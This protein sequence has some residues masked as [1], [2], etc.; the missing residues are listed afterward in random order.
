VAIPAVALLTGFVALQ[1]LA[2]RPLLPLP[3]LRSRPVIG[4]NLVLAI[5]G[6]SMLGF[7]YLITLYFQN[8]LGYSP[9]RA[10]FGILPIAIGIGALSL[11]GY[12]R[13]SQ[14][15]GPRALIV[16]GMLTVGRDVPTRIRP[17]KRPLRQLGSA[18]HAAVRR[19]WRRQ[20][21]R[22]QIVSL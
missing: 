2:R 8:V 10:G 20:S 16:P 21:V 3:V 18:E 11:F 9:A 7:Q 12:P 4:A 19:W 1:I 6:G 5:L 13:I 15:T 14:R 17:D 22:H